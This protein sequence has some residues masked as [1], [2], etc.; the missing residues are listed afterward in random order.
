M[1]TTTRLYYGWEWVGWG[2]ELR[3]SV[4]LFPVLHTKESVALLPTAIL[5]YLARWRCDKWKLQQD[6]ISGCLHVCVC[7]RAHVCVRA[8]MY[9]YVC[10]CVCVCVCVR[11][12]ASL[13][14]VFRTVV[15]FY[16]KRL[17]MQQMSRRCM[18]MCIIMNKR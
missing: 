11:A 15:L 4:R 17:E 7:V 14:S 10:V 2:A 5:F 3:V 18:C 8:C 16:L 1:E 12:L 6:S 9:V 13:C